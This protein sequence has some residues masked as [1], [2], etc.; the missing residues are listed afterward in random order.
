MVSSLLG[1]SSSRK[2]LSDNYLDF[3]KRNVSHL[4]KVF[5]EHDFMCTTSLAEIRSSQGHVRQF[6]NQPF[7]NRMKHRSAAQSWL[8]WS[9][10]PNRF[11]YQVLGE[12]R[13]MV[14]ASK[15]NIT[16]LRSRILIVVIL[17][18]YAAVLHVLASPMETRIR[19]NH[20]DGGHCEQH[21]LAVK[22][23]IITVLN[24]QFQ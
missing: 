20:P 17:I 13:A 19:C 18:I 6:M 3:C 5:N 4:K 10:V 2:A 23:A 24:K 14:H 8:P 22:Y 1:S 11:D 16:E 9:S 12:V 15:L 21:A 7:R